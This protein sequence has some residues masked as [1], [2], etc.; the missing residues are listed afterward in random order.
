M[1]MYRQNERGLTRRTRDLLIMAICALFVLNCVQYFMSRTSSERDS[2]IREMFIA[3][4]RSE[5]D[6]ARTNAAQISRMGSTNTYRLQAITRQHL[7]GISQLNDMTGTLLGNREALL[8]QDV[9][10]AAIRSVDACSSRNLEG[11]ASDEQLAE[12][13]VQLDQLALAAESL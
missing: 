5:L 10:A 2:V 6:S 11:F 4:V 12:L 1:Y 13:R 8:P 3:R 7:Y 9:V